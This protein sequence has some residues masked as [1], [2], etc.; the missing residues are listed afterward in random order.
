MTL[1]TGVW[2]ILL[3]VLAASHLILARQ[4]NARDIIEKITPF[5]GWIG[6]ISFLWGLWTLFISLLLLGS[7]EIMPIAWLVRVATGVLLIGLGLVLGLGI[8]K[9]VIKHPP[10]VQW[11][12]RLHR[13]LEPKQ[14]AL[15]LVS[16]CVGIFAVF[17]ALFL[18]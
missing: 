15:G 8:M 9:E 13:N 2:M 10:T 11:M 4:P 18:R 6:V 7:T 14:G 5:Q 17:G 3:G 16:I 1:F 12:D